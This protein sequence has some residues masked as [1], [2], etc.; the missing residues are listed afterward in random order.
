MDLWHLLMEFDKCTFS[1]SS[2]SHLR[3]FV[4]TSVILTPGA[5]L[6][7]SLVAVRAP[8]PRDPGD[9]LM[10]AKIDFRTEQI[11]TCAFG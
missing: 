2:H 9:P 11:G 8:F 6:G 1:S 10:C 5:L 7:W 3:E 4:K